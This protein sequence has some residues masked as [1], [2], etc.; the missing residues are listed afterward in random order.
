V[1]TTSIPFPV[2]T[3]GSSGPQVVAL[4]NALT[5]AGFSPG[6]ADGQ[7][8]PETRAAVLAFQMRQN[9]TAD[10]IAGPATVAALGLIPPPPP[11]AIPG[12]TV[13]VVAQM[14]PVTPVANIQANLPYVLNALVTATLQDTPMVL[15]ALSTIRAETE[16][17]E[18]ISEYESQ[19]NT[20]PGGPPFSKYDYD[21]ELGN[22]GPPDGANFRGRGFVQL[23]GR[24]NYTKYG[25]QAGLDLVNNPTLANDPQIA[26]TLLA[27]F[28][29]DSETAIRAALAANDL[30]QARKL[31]NGGENGMALFESAYTI[32]KGLIP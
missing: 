15:M 14:F 21:A 13:A 24:Y 32:G 30:K 8:G 28:L 12:V 31:V 6:G 5:A 25:A 26:A 16:S 27:L 9:L 22:L 17:F 1:A 20:P 4:Q 2:L 7:F 19:F 18:P 23:T 11:L 29:A 3:E 10:G